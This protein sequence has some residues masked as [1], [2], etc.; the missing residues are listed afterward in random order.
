MDTVSPE[1]RSET[2]S[3]IRSK[4]TKPELLVRH[5]LHMLGFRYRLHSPKLPGHPDIVLPKWHTVIFING[6]FWHRHEG[7][8]VA[9][10][11]KSNVEFWTKKFE[12]NVAR[13]KK[14]QAALKEAGWHVL[15]VWECEIK[16]RL[17]SLADDIKHP[18]QA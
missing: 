1:K 9:T 12:R 5:H 3:K 6:C 8:K 7:C 17:N 16:K 14:E 18:S 10:M 11:P 4:N 2:M 15:V 13:D